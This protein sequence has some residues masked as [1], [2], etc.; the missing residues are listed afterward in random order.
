VPVGGA[1]AGTV[2]S[3]PNVVAVTVDPGPRTS[4]TRMPVRHRQLCFLHH[5]LH[6]IDHVLVDTGSVGVRVLE[7]AIGLTLPAATNASGV[8][9]AECTP[10]VG[11]TS[12]GT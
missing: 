7:T 11:G 4:V 1:D 10:F 3:G 9:L 2:G 6:T 8:A 12:W 5:D